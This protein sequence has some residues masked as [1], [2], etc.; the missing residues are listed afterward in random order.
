MHTIVEDKDSQKNTIF[1]KRKY[2]E[3]QSYTLTSKIQVI[4]VR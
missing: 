2:E 3:K 4:L 1:E